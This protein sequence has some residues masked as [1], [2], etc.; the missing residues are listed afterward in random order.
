[1]MANLICTPF[2]RDCSIRVRAIRFESTGYLA[3]RPNKYQA[4][5]INWYDRNNDGSPDVLIA[6]EDNATLWRWWEKPFKHKDVK[7]KDDRFRWKLLAYRNV[8]NQ[9]HWLQLGLRGRPGNREA[10]GT[11]ITLVTTRGRQG[12]VVGSNESSYFSKDTIVSISGLATRP[13]STT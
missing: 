12:R 6:L 4:A 5:I 2:R 7:G 1:M 3:L 11:R 10:I 13:K 9:G 8:G